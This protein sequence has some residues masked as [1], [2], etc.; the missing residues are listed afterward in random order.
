MTLMISCL[1]AGVILGSAIG[2]DSADA[3]M[4][5][6]PKGVETRWASMENPDAKKG[7]GGKERCGRKGSA[8]RG[9]KAGETVVLAHAEGQGMVRRMW[10]TTLPNVPKLI[11]GL[12]IRMYWDG[13][14]KPAVEAPIGD[15]F[16]QPLGKQFTFE[17]AWFDNPE[18][19]SYNCRIPMP[20]RK[21]FKITLTNETPED[22][23][24]L[25]YDVNYTIG[26]KLSPDTCYFHAYYNR[27]NPTVM[28]RDYEILPK[29]TGRGRYLGT[30]FGIIADTK[31]WGKAW[32]GEG[33]FKVYVDG[34]KDY[35]TIC[36]TGTEDYIST[37]WGQGKFDFQWHGCPYADHENL[38]YAFYRLHGPD[39][40]FFQKDF[41]ATIQQLGCY[42]KKSMLEFMDKNNIK[43]FFTWGEPN[44]ILTYDMIKEGGDY[45]GIER[46]DDWCSVA[47]FYFDKPTTDL[48]AIQPYEKRI[49]GIIDLGAEGGSAGTIGSPS[50]E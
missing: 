19:R 48:P 6:V 50:Q 25:Y 38:V 24:P 35:P 27:E 39:P 14:D 21:G 28:R 37:A 1:A 26:D 34:D 49:E 22:M 12:V 43:E 23:Y 5:E 13:S 44:T 10:I 41:R 46:E 18:G 8:C 15:F 7:E 4:F 33:E 42:E 16:C 11:R 29:I 30:S 17:N 2:N 45:G 31:R 20:F 3:S 9:M 32:W 40:L 47:Y 36:G